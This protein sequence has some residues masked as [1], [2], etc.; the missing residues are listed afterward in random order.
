MTAKVS[1]VIPAY[2]EA[3]RL[4]AT[5][6]AV[7][8]FMKQRGGPFEVVV[9]NDGSK[10]ATA[11]V[12]LSAGPDV[13]LIENP[14]NRGKGYAVRNGMLQAMGDLRL[15]CDADL[16]TPI[17][18]LDALEKALGNGVEIALASRA[19][20][21]AR[22]E[23]RQSIFREMSGRFFNGIVRLL[24]VPG[25]SDT[26]CGFKLF[27]ARAAEAAFRSATLD[28]FAFDVEAL[29]LARRA[30]FQT[31]EVPVRWINDEQT[32]VSLGRGLMAFADLFRLWWRL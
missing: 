7:L 30:G 27:T 2:N 8:A 24:L 13:R 3:L 16:S 22:L 17:E 31:K 9:V 10:D 15:M 20:S 11:A 18:E 23:K 21:G 26:Q 12:A 25:V 32:T 1:V 6:A 5:L 14:G 28:G 19:V 4:P 29:Y